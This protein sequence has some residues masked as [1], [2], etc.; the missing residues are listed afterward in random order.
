MLPAGGR[1]GAFCD[2]IAEG[3]EFSESLGEVIGRFIVLN[4]GRKSQERG[5]EPSLAAS[6][7]RRLIPRDPPPALIQDS[8]ASR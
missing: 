1:T 7:L 4:M 3:G 6:R 8:T 2:R 5:V